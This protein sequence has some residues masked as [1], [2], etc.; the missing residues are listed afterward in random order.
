MCVADGRV[1]IGCHDGVILTALVG[2]IPRMVALPIGP[3]LGS[4]A[5]EQPEDQ[6][7]PDTMMVIHRA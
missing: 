7:H 6:V 2:D 3:A 4:D 5:S 1:T